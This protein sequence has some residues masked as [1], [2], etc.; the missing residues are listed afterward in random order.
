[1]RNQ[2][3]HI[4]AISRGNRNS[5]SNPSEQ[6]T[7]EFE[8]DLA[9][10]SFLKGLAYA[11]LLAVLLGMVAFN[12]KY[13]ESTYETIPKIATFSAIELLSFVA[14]VILFVGL[15]VLMF[16]WIV[17]T[18]DEF[19]LWKLWLNNP[20][21][22][23][24]QKAT[25]IVFPV[26]MGIVPAFPNHIVVTS[27]FIAIYSL[28]N[29]WTQ[30]LCNDHFHHALQRTRK[31]SL[32]S[33]RSEVL[34]VM[35]HFW[36]RRPQLGRIATMMFF[37]CIAFSFALAGSVQQEPQGHRFRLTAYAVLFLNLLINEIILAT[38]RYKL[39]QKIHIIETDYEDSHNK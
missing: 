15:V 33:V 6:A 18:Q 7:R 3:K 25:L 4:A 19:D 16:R 14:P 28:V 22:Q 23:Q 21:T 1:M 17:A 35:E 13:F 34:T 36:L 8:V 10:T 24:E 29:Y 30:W 11:E 32:D 31:T 26:F 5:P 9:E 20:L 27:G 12:A 37:N 2:K 39:H 38:W